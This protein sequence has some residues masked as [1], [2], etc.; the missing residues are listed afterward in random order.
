[1]PVPLAIPLIGLGLSGIS[2]GLNI[3]NSRQAG[4]DAEFSGEMQARQRSTQGAREI[5]ELEQRMALSGVE[6]TGYTGGANVN[7]TEPKAGWLFGLFG[8]QEGGVTQDDIYDDFTDTSSLLL[9]TSRDAIS[10]DTQLIRMG[11]KDLAQA[12]R[13]EGLNYGID[14]L[15]DTIDFASN[16]WDDLVDWVS[17]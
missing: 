1:M 12:Y 9:S 16:N 5:G 11:A 8:R 7:V 4:M 6:T 17:G 2:L 15:G 3:H 10:M 13:L 14:F